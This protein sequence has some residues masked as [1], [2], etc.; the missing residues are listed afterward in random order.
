MYLAKQ[1][2]NELIKN[3]DLVVEP[4]LEPDAQIGETSIDFRLG[5][6]Y[7]VSIQGRSAYLDASYG[8]T[9]YNIESS[10]QY[11]RRNIGE[12]FLIHPG[13]IVLAVSL[14]YVKLPN[15]IGLNLTM[16]SS[17]SRMGLLMSTFVQPGYCGCLS[18]EILNSSKSVIKLVAGA[19]LIQGRLFSFEEKTDYNASPRKYFCTIKPSVS[20]IRE[21]KDMEKLDKIFRY[22]N[23][24]DEN[25]F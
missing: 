3:R 21:E 7:L 12:P 2:I 18:I 16:R 8:N 5:L 15:E 17:Y 10:F 13:Q 24:V 11:T 4:L 25:S 1:K 9:S 20:R 6:E 22:D 14:E 23:H 19:R